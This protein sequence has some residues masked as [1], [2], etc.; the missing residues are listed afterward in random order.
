[1]HSGGCTPDAPLLRGELRQVLPVGLDYD[2][3][4]AVVRTADEAVI[5]AIAKVFRRFSEL[6]N[7]RQ[8]LL[9]LRGGGPLVPRRPTRT[10]CISWQ[11]AT[12]SAVQDFLTNPAY[13][14][15]LVIGRTRTEKRV[16]GDGRIVIRT[17][18]LPRE[19]C[20]VLISDHQP[21]FIDW[22]TYEAKTGH[23]R[24]THRLRTGPRT[25][26]ARIR[27]KGGAA[28]YEAAWARRKYDAVEPE[29]RLLGATLERALETKLAAQRSSTFGK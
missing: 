21:G 14:G 4:K 24:S 3:A 15:P 5:E 18:L 23:R 19:Q 22:A 16:D 12:Y 28:R 26:P 27:T 17:V 9:S 7:A 13:A 2:E 29:N 11:A 20:T 8:V 1:M 25:A 10:D 6:G